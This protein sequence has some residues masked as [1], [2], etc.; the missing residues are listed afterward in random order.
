MLMA[1]HLLT[2]QQNSSSESIDS[3]TTRQMLEV[4]NRADQEVATRSS[5]RNS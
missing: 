5:E 2:E 4:I 3:L 1:H